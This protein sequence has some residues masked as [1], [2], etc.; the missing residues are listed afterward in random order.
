MISAVHVIFTDIK[1]KFVFIHGGTNPVYSL[2]F[3]YSIG[4]EPSNSEFFLPLTA[5][6]HEDDV[7]QEHIPEPNSNYS[8]GVMQED[9]MPELN[10]E[11]NCAKIK[12]GI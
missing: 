4:K 8:L 5:E 11:E 3:H 6:S 2:P 12:E 10:L 9:I 1:V 7:I